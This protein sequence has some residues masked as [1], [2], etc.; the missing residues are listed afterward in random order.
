MPDQTDTAELVPGV[1]RNPQIEEMVLIGGRPA[2]VS[3]RPATPLDAYRQWGYFT[4]Y[5]GARIPLSR[6][7]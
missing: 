3:R 4:G 5:V 1:T 2:V 6:T 7:R